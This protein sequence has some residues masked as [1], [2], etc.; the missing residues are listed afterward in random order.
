[1]KHFYFFSKLSFLLFFTII[2]GKAEAQLISAKTNAILWGNVTPNLSVELVTSKKTSLEI[3]GFYSPDKT[4]LSTSLR[5]GQM[6]LRYWI[7]GRP[8]SW[9]F[10]G[11]SATALQYD[12]S[13]GTSFRH[14]GDAVG[15]GILFGYALPIATHWNIEFA[16]GMGLLWFREKKYDEK[17]YIEKQPYNN[18]GM[19]IMPTKLSV[20]FAYVF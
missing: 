13:A 19:K 10:T 7:S 8:M 14:A 15:P 2:C 5:G 12:F 4:P 9:L 20:S 3:T 11:I 18:R 6:E 17:Q 16:T 1:M